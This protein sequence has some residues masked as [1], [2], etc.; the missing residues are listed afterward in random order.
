MKSILILVLIVAVSSLSSNF[1]FPVVSSEQVCY[2]VWLLKSDDGLLFVLGIPLVDLPVANS[3]HATVSGTVLLPAYIGK[4]WVMP[5]PTYTADIDARIIQ[6]NGK[7]YTIPPKNVVLDTGINS[8]NV[9]NVSVPIPGT[10][11]TAP[12]PIQVYGILFYE[13]APCPGPLGANG[14]RASPLGDNWLNGYYLVEGLV[15]TGIILAVSIVGYSVLRK[16]G[17]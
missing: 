16:K 10:N 9:S 4:A 13:V 1:L 14:P 2:S 15:F 12:S 6:V 3:S 7:T 11:L 8:S 17:R 5:E